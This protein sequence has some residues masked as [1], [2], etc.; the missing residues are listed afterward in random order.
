MHSIQKASRRLAA[1][2]HALGRPT[3]EKECA[4]LLGRS[5]AGLS[6]RLSALDIKK[7]AQQK[8]HY[9]RLIKKLSADAWLWQYC[10]FLQDVFLCNTLSFG[11]A[12][13]DSDI[14]IFII[15]K[16]NRLFTAR[17][18]ITLLAHISGRRRYGARTRGR[19]C[20]S[21]FISP[22]AMDFSSIRLKGG[23]PYLALWLQL[24][25]PLAGSA[26]PMQQKNMWARRLFPIKPHKDAPPPSTSLIASSVHYLL[27]G[28]LGD[29]V[30]SCVK[31]WQ[32]ARIAKKSHGKKRPLK[33]AVI[34]NAHMLKFHETDARGHYQKAW[35]N[36]IR[37]VE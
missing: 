3:S 2:F 10:P 9:K 27:R 16:K 11:F 6:S 12:E 7:R 14:D 33:A 32:L 1:F 24:L 17:L 13:K 36:I 4:V 31:K 15:A 23:D 35:R 29:A 19:L 34:A 30:E 21:F 26:R 22:A 18:F 25:H 5:T 20:L 8:A 28:R 37:S